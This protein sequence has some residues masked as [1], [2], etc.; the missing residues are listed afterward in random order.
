MSHDRMLSF[1]A[2]ITSPTYG[3]QLVSCCRRPA[4]SDARV[5]SKC[6]VRSNTVTAVA[7]GLVSHT[8]LPPLRLLSNS[9]VFIGPQSP[10]KTSGWRSAPPAGYKT[11][12]G[13]SIPRCLTNGKGTTAQKWLHFPAEQASR[14]KKRSGPCFFLCL[15]ACFVIP[16]TNSRVSV[17]LPR[18]YGDCGGFVLDVLLSTTKFGKGF[19]LF[20]LSRDT[21]CA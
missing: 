11:R 12:E 2:T 18:A 10:S 21:R 6:Y 14:K 1:G 20:G 13:T 8:A 5:T 4:S 3:E 9:C 15:L 17:A 19:F 7:F 16:N